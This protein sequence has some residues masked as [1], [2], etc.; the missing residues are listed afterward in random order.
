MFK[1]ILIAN[2]GE[3]AVRVIRACRE[4]GITTIAVY[5]DVD[6]AALHVRKADE[7]YHIGPAPAAESYLCADKILDVAKRSGAEAIHPGY[8]FLSENSTF[9]QACADAG[10]KFI[11][12]SP[13]SMEMMGSKTRARQEMEKAGVPSVPG[14]SHGLT[15]PEEGEQIAGRIGYPVM[16]KAAAG[17]GGKGMRLV[18]RREEL[19]S[20]LESAQSEAKRSFGDGEVYIEKAIVNPR[21]IEMQVLADEHGNTV[22]LAERECSIQRRHQKVLEESPSPIVDPEM[23]RRMGEI[24]VKVAQAANYTNAGTVEFL[25][26]Q[27][28]NFYFLEMNTRLQVEH[29]VTELI[30]GLDLVHLQ[31]RIASGEK[32]PFGQ[33]NV[34]IRGHAIECRIYAEDPDNHYFPSPGKITLLL[35]PSGPGIRRDSGMY[36]G[37]DVPMEY[38]PLLA[39]LISYGTDRQQAIMRLQRALYEYFVAGIK[40]NISL[41]QRILRDRDF[42]AGK[43]D[44]GY[45]DRLL[46]QKD[47]AGSRQA[48]EPLIAAIAAGLFAA[49]DP[50]SAASKNGKRAGVEDVPSRWKHRGRLEATR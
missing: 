32:L 9:A 14:T 7:A 1:K 2:R 49:F 50:A 33:E 30:T 31:I 28:K 4:M 26:D 18:H 47:T 40:T 10:L 23:R 24:A 17:G 35:A 8:G 45:L 39:K 37:W 38:D 15:S 25:V 21:H 48:E 12:P 20:A 43:L 22:W 41:F 34:A 42:Q 19:R 11:G 44:T 13:Q 29:P 5:S 16:L 36:E 27:Q 6:R 3:I 46:A